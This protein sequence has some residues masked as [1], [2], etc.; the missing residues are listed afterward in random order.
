MDTSLPKPIGGRRVPRPKTVRACST[1][2]EPLGADY[3]QC[4]EC[5]EAIERIWL[6]DWHALLEQE[7][8]APGSADENLLAHVVLSEFGRHPWTVVDIAMSLLRCSQCG[9][10]LGEAYADCSECGMAFGSSILCEFDATGNEHA[11]H[12]GRWVLRYPHRHSKNAVAA[13]RLTVP[14]LLT[15][16]LPTTQGA[17]QIMA[18]IKAGRMQEVE[19]AVAEL[20]AAIN[21]G[22]QGQ[23][24]H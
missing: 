6:A 24:F 7:Q 12:V 5:H 14:R 11:L 16:W 9:A 15:G 21:Q 19:R 13:W 2:A 18:L 1:C 22:S 20:D 3:A 17:Q 10:E 8:I 4:P 23:N